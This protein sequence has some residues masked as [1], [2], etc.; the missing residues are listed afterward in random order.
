MT[1]HMTL[2][3]QKALSGY[4]K[5][6]KNGPDADFSISTL[7]GARTAVIW[8][9][10]R[11]TMFQRQLAAGDCSGL[12]MAAI[13]LVRSGSLNGDLGGNP[14]LLAAGSVSVMDLAGDFTITSTDDQ[15]VGETLIFVNRHRLLRLLERT[16]QSL[17]E[18]FSLPAAGLYGL[19]DAAS[20]PHSTPWSRSV[21]D[22]FGDMVVAALFAAV[23]N[24]PSSG[25]RPGAGTAVTLAG[26]CRFID[27]NLFS[28]AL[29]PDLIAGQFGLS[30]ASLF[31]L[32]KPVGGVGS[33]IRMQRM[34]WVAGQI[35]GPSFTGQRISTYARQL[36]FSNVS[37][38]SRA[39]RDAYGVAP[40]E[41]REATRGLE[42]GADQNPDSFSAWLARP[43][44]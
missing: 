43:A 37:A 22:A 23:V 33:Y 35:S 5:P 26:L 32:F 12:A 41:F 27:Q 18:P 17:I 7:V 25:P 11:S 21:V 10:H 28:T 16:G 19:I 2:S 9:D 1:T 6:H 8:L 3:D 4:C 30:R 15:A 20:R 38:F 24:E 40:G 42:A 14:C 31:R 34:G 13:R 39:F 44:G 36:G 29:E